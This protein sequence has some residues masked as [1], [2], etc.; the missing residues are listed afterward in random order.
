MKHNWFANSIGV[1][2]LALGTAWTQAEVA[3]AVSFTP[4]A[5]AASPRGTTGG[6]SRDGFFTPPADAASPRGT[7]GGASRGGFFTPSSENAS[8]RGTTGGASRGDFFT[9]P[10]DAASPRGTTGGASRDGF[11]TPSPDA[12][13]PQGSTGGASRRIFN[14]LDE[15]VETTNG[16]ARSNVYGETAALPISTGTSMLAVMPDSFFGKTIEARPTI[17]VYVPASKASE[18]VFSLKDEV[19]QSVYEMTVAV[20]TSG[21]IVAVELPSEAPALTVDQNYQWYLALKIDGAL[22]PASPF[23]DGW[24]KRVSPTSDMAAS[25]SSNAIAQI[26]ALGS[27]GIWYDTASKLASLRVARDDAAISQHWYEL[28]ESVGLAEIAAAPIVVEP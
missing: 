17:L 20:P 10:A 4:P 7:T 18:A 14:R 12:G 11:F 26:E 13:S 15:S 25:E 1:V 21:G 27:N 19:K 28:L 22:Q 23:V 3:H 6:A 5:D 16:S 9:P 2:A 8:P 24:V